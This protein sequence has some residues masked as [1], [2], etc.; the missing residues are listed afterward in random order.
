MKLA[1]LLIIIFSVSLFSQSE[2]RKWGKANYSYQIQNPFNKRDYSVK[3]KNVGNVLLK[4][5]IDAYWFFISDVDGDNCSFRP[6]CSSFFFKSV[7]KTNIFQGVLMF[8]DRFTRD[9]DIMKTGL[10]PRVKDGHYYDPPEFYELVKDKIKYIPSNVVVN[11]ESRLGDF[12]N[13]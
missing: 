8:A 4:T 11:Y 5:G 10:Y 1:F 12:M 3:G 7:E 2:R 13:N 9:T 6:T